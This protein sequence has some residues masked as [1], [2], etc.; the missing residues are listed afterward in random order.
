[1]NPQMTLTYLQVLRQSVINRGSTVLAIAHRLQTI[2]DF[3]R[4]LVLGQGGVLE[5]DSP[6][7]LMADE[8]SIFSNM[9]HDGHH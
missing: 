6:A 1:M 4:I 5:F 2:I 7:N 3:D 8:N 9:L